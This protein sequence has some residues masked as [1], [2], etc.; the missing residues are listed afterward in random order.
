MYRW[1][2]LDPDHL[3]RPDVGGNPIQGILWGLLLAL[4]FWVP[5]V[6]GVYFG[7]IR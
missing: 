7:M 6:A 4:A 2:D 1:D 3:A 5:V